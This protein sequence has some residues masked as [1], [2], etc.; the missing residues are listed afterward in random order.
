M[1]REAQRLQLG[2][3]EVERKDAA[4]GG[5][6]ERGQTPDAA[7]R[8][9]RRGGRLGEHGQHLVALP[10]REVH[11][12]PELT[13]ELAQHRR[14][15]RDELRLSDARGDG[16]QTPAEPVRERLPVALDEAVLLERPQRPRE[17]ALVAADEPCQGDDPEA[18]SGGRLLGQRAQ[19]LEP[20]LESGRA[21]IHARTLIGSPSSTARRST[22]STSSSSIA[23][24]S[25]GA[26]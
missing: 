21:R 1:S 4:G 14:R 7:R 24:S 3:I 8:V 19:D 12:L 15:R 18:V 25:D 22:Y 10:H 17:L 9:Q 26:S 6:R 11:A 5:A 23:S 20:P 16:E 2:G 13:H